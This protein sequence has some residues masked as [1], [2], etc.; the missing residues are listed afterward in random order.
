MKN[1]IFI[2]ICFLSINTY[3]QV[4][5]G[6]VMIGDVVDGQVVGLVKA[7]EYSNLTTTVGAMGQ[8]PGVS[9]TVQS[10]TSSPA[11]AATVYFGQLPKAP[12]AINTNRI[13][14]RQ[15]G[16][17]T[18]ANIYCYSGTAGSAE[19]WSLYIRKNNTTDYLIQTLSVSANERVFFNSVMSIPIIAGDYIEIKSVQPTWVTNPLT[20]IFGGYF[21]L[22]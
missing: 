1:L 17:I 6:N 19:A 9:F 4:V 12:S 22:K 15:S 14:F 10:L 13:Y 8:P 3:S 16:T 20:T 18:I 7:T 2:L 21:I 5:T 11:D